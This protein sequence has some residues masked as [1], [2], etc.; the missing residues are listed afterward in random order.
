MSHKITIIGGGSSIFTPQLIALF[1]KSKHLRGSVV[2]LMDINPQRLELMDI[3][4]KHLVEQT[5]S[6]LKIESTTDR[7]Q[8]LEGADFVITTISVG[9][10]DAWENDIE[11]PA[12]YG[13]YQPIG[14]SVGPGGIMRAFRHVLPM[15]E[16]CQEL[17]KVSPDAW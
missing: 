9:G 10:F 2:T 6:D 17:E 1:I 8:S 12:K 13:V 16:L 7:R 3:L 15:V 11:I 14:D 4:S 5:G